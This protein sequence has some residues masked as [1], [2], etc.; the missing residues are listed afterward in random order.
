MSIHLH[1]FY[2]L[3]FSLIEAIY[4][5]QLNRTLQRQ[6]QAYKKKVCRK[7]AEAL[8]SA[9][10]EQDHELMKMLYPP[11]FKTI[12]T[13]EQIH[14]VSDSENRSP[15]NNS[16]QPMETNS[17]EELLQIAKGEL[18][19]TI[20][21]APVKEFI[22]DLSDFVEIQQL[23]KE[24]GHQSKGHA[25]HIIFTGNPGTGK[26]TIARIVAKIFKSL[27]VLSKGHLVEV[28]REDLVGAH[29]GQTAEKTQ[30]VIQQALGGIL[31]I[32]EAYTLNRG[33]EQDFG[34]E[35]ID[36]IVKHMEDHYDDLIVILAGY[37]K[38]MDDFLEANSGLKSRF[39]HQIEFPDYTARELLQIMKK[40][41][42]DSEYAIDAET[43]RCLIEVIQSKQ[44]KGSN[45][46]GNGRMVRNM[47]QD[48]IRKQAK[49]LKRE[50]LLDQKNLLRL[51]AEDFGYER[52]S[53]FNLEQELSG[54]IGNDE[55]KKHIKM[56]A[57][58]VKINK[59]R[60]EKGIGKLRDH[61]FH[62]IFKGNPGTGKT[63][64]ARI[65]SGMLSDMGVLKTGKLVE[66]G[67]S[68]LVG[69]YVGHTAIKTKKV[70]QKALGGI[71]FIDE[72]YAL[73]SG[74]SSDFGQ[75]AINTLIKEMEDHREN[76]IVI[77]AGYED[78]M[79]GFLNSNPGLDSRFPFHF[80]FKDYS[81]EELL[82]ILSKVAKSE[83][84]QIERNVREI[85]YS[86]LQNE[87]TSHHFG[88]GR[89]IR[90]LYE[91]AVQA[92]A[93]RLSKEKIIT[94]NEL[95]LLKESDFL[96]ALLQKQ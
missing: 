52:E 27:G 50:G 95:Q 7:Q 87:S 25:L 67:R 64:L 83:G 81:V 45:A 37:S 31:F 39:P 90:N 48:A 66:V 24:K 19:H 10:L 55:L 18:N 17:T 74:G 63:T 3:L 13:N 2:L 53:K 9:S 34:K 38:E 92:Q 12:N 21:L 26:T 82:E 11:N 79:Q 76:L 75:E 96:E 41:I 6:Y 65:I 51:V 93:Y 4:F 20:G 91:K 88:N 46:N 86:F 40:M 94:T 59:L 71:L 58:Q 15:V 30:A 5:Y 89:Y 33:G 36:T 73:S 28:A 16:R 14:S 62:M 23:R 35:A 85:L 49:R 29:V 57:A 54:F 84:F 43:E 22:S 60:N 68:D 1:S 70:V 47:L 61:S 8:K 77:L 72:A 78:E 80:T 42:K 32:D 56:L 44:I 69:E